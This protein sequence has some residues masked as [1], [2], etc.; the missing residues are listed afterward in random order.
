MGD[1][2][3]HQLPGKEGG[4]GVTLRFG[5]VPLQ[6]RLRGALAEVGLEDRGEG[7]SA[8]RP[9]S[10]LPVSLRRHRR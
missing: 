3:G 9:P 2:R 1:D 7:E 8:T 4:G 5:K 6:D 10:P